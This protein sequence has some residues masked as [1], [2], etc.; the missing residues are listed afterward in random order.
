VEVEAP[1]MVLPRSLQEHAAE[2][3]LADVQWMFMYATTSLLEQLLPIYPIQ[4]TTAS[5]LAE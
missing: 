4:R 5:A 2:T 1:Q 3:V